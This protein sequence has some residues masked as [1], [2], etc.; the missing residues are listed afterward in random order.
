MKALICV[1][2]LWV[3]IAWTHEFDWSTLQPDVPSSGGLILSTIRQAP[4]PPSVPLGPDVHHAHGFD[5]F[6]F[7]ASKDY[8]RDG[9]EAQGRTLHDEDPDWL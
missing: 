4:Q 3:T 6:P 9:R 8:V 5:G 2:G 1:L 7:G